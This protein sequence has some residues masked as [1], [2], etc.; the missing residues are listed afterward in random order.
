MLH[1]IS[2]LFLLLCSLTVW[3]DGLAD[4]EIYVEQIGDNDNITVRQGG[5]ATGKNR[6][7]VYTSG[8]GNTLKLN[9][10][11]LTDGSVSFDDSNNHYLYLN[12]SGNS[13]TITTRQTDGSLSGTGHFQETTISGNSNII[14]LQQ[15]GSGSKIL[16]TNVNGGNNAVTAAQ[17]GTGQH[18]LDINL[19]GNGHT[20][21]ALQD[22]IGNHAAIIKLNNSGGG[23]TVNM[24]QLGSTPQTYSIDQTCVNAAGCNTTITQ[25]Q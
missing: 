22:G 17:E 5:S 16:F 23:S 11:Y 12:N 7:E 25:G 4:N 24:N 15:T 20:V 9:Q 21:N 1:R 18:Y 19:L 8:N 3:A 13:N 10:G 6:M 2:L 14:N